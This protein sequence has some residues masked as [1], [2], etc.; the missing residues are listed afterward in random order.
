METTSTAW[1]SI[2]FI[3]IVFFFQ[4]KTRARDESMYYDIVIYQM[5]SSK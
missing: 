4:H 2:I 3:E 5:K 1:F